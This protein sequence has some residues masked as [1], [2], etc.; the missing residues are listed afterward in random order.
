M[1]YSLWF[2][3]FFVNFLHQPSVESDLSGIFA[4]DVVYLPFVKRFQQKILLSKALDFFQ[5]CGTVI[6]LYQNQKS[7][8]TVSLLP[9]Y[10]FNTFL[11]SSCC[12]RTHCY[13]NL[14]IWLLSPWEKGTT[15]CSNCKYMRKLLVGWH[16][17]LTD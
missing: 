2:R 6:L 1:K 5:W 10:H 17:P 4:L 3:V 14:C 15:K 9:L 11:V 8:L 16:P 12:E 13:V 7:A